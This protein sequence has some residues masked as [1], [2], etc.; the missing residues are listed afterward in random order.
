L[1]HLFVTNLIFPNFVASRHQPGHLAI[2]FNRHTRRSLNSLQRLTHRVDTIGRRLLHLRAL[3]K[4]EPRVLWPPQLLVHQPAEIV[5]ARIKTSCVNG[6]RERLVRFARPAGEIV[7][8]SPAKELIKQVILR[9][10]RSRR[11]RRYR[12]RDNDAA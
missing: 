11:G 1:L 6:V 12:R 4:I 10:G 3:L 7:M 2:L 8:D 5:N 9:G